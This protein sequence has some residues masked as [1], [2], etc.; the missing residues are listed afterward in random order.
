MILQLKRKFFAETYTI[1]SLFVNG[2][3]FCDT[4]EDTNRDKNHDGDLNDAGEGK[5]YAK[6]C[7]PFGT[8]EVIVNLSPK[9]KRMLPRLLNVP[10]FD[11]ILIHAGNSADSSAGCIIVG[12]N[13][14]KGGVI[15]SK[16][17]EDKLTKLLLA[18]QAKKENIT[19]EIL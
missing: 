5:I 17:Y 19:I 10:H 12:E 8:Y 11:G 3:Y 2:A 16:V 18:T 6:T 15:N 1:G 9:K 13:K 4:V 14:V 7:I